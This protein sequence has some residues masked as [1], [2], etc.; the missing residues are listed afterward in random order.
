MLRN[1]VVAAW[2]M[3]LNLQ[4]DPQKERRYRRVA[5]AREYLIDL[6]PK[7]AA[8]RAGYSEGTARKA[9]STLMKR[10]DV[11]R[12]IAEEAGHRA[13]RTSVRVDTVV[14]ELARVGFSN[15]ATFLTRSADGAIEISLAKASDYDLAV[16]KKVVQDRIGENVVRTTIEMHDKLSALRDLLKHTVLA[17]GGVTER[18]EH[19]FPDLPEDLRARMAM[20]VA[21][22]PEPLMIEAP[23][24]QSAEA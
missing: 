7:Q 24:Q 5:F 8:L 21:E 13:L 16:V 17:A 11:Q 4:A 23:E 14:E 22:A 12:L 1:H 6:D 18:E 20:V 3:S 15:I 9:K 19:R 10:Q 2:A